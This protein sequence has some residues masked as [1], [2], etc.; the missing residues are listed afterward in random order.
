MQFRSEAL[1]LAV[2]YN[3]AR[4]EIVPQNEYFERRTDYQTVTI[5]K[6]LGY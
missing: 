3:E 2:D 5:L 4:T 1:F 6:R